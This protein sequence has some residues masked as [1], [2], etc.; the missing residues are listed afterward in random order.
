MELI[1]TSNREN[2][3]LVR[4]AITKELIANGFEVLAERSQADAVLTWESQVE[5]VLHGDGTDPDKSIFTWQLL[6]SDNKPIWKYSIKFVSKKTPDDDLAYA[7]QRLAKKL[8]DDKN[9]AMK[10]GA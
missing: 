4:D 8:S 1:E 3:D 2:I 6:L 9:K 10:K 7:A 5:I